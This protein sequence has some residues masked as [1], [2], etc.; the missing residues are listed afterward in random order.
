MPW[1]ALDY[2]DRKRK[3]QLSNMFGVNGIPALVIIGS[4]GQLITKEGRAA[5]TADPLGSSFPW[6]PKPVADLKTGPGSLPD[7]PTFIA[8]C[9][10]C[11]PEEQEK[12]AS[13]MTPLAQ[14]FLDEQKNQGS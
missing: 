13:A 5:V 4:D 14:R 3:D 10:G 6:Y 8:F 12:A 1:L 2:S 9:E 11:T 7:V